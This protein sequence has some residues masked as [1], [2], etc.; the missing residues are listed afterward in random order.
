MYI[1]WWT[2]NRIHWWY[3]TKCVKSTINITN[4]LSLR[5]EKRKKTALAK[6]CLLFHLTLNTAIMSFDYSYNNSLTNN[7]NMNMQVKNRLRQGH[8]FSYPR[9]KTCFTAWPRLDCMCTLFLNRAPDQQIWL[10]M[11]YSLVRG[12][13][14]RNNCFFGR[15]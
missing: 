13:C 10:L 6:D 12:R 5:M 11:D 3:A 2:G 1:Y 7:I 4:Y 15:R 8:R 9:R 14:H